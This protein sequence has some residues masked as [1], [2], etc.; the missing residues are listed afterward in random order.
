MTTP[1]LSVRDL[2]IEFD[3]LIGR[4]R[5]VDRVSF[6]LMEGE[7]LGVL[8]ESGSGKTVSTLAI[9]GLIDGTPGVVDGQI[10]LRDG[11]QTVDLLAGLPGV[12]KGPPGEQQKNVRAWN[13][14][15]RQTMKARWGR[16]MTA[17]FQNPRASLDPLQTIG[18]QIDE[19]IRLAHPALGRDARRRKGIDWLDRVRLN[20]PARVYRAFGHELSGG[21]C[22]RAMIAIALAREP[23]ILVADEPTTGLD[24]TVRS[25]IV[26][27]FRV[28]IEEEAKS[29]VYISH[30]IREV[31]YLS[32]N[33]VVMRSGRVIEMTAA[34]EIASMK[35]QRAP[36]TQ[37]L[38][39]A[40]GLVAGVQ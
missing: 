21:M 32:T 22:Q 38:L 28:L 35:G 33:I 7:V 8:G 34:D 27:L 1:L 6:D 25:E 20:Q 18:R 39:E 24:S 5:V 11:P 9:L 31:L 3:T 19:S 12:L 16:V 15:V 40:A 17:V 30:D 13:R 26:E 23:L 4:R 14:L 36:Y 29:M 10:L 37:E 2:T